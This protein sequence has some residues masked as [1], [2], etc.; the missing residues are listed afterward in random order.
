VPNPSLDAAKSWLADERKNWTEITQTVK[1]E[2]A[3]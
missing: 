3:E 1:I 2:L